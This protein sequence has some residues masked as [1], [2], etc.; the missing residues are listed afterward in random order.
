MDGYVILGHAPELYR[1]V[2]GAAVRVRAISFTGL[3]GIRGTFPASWGRLAQ[4]EELDLSGTGMGGEIP[5]EWNGM[6]SL[7]T[8]V[9]S[10]TKACSGLP[11]WKE[12]SMP[13]L[14]SVD[15]SNNGMRGPLSRNFGTFS[16]R[17]MTLDISGNSFCGCVPPTW[18]SSV[19]RDAAAAADPVLLQPNCGSINACNRKIYR[20]MYNDAA[21]LATGSPLLV[22]FITVAISFALVCA[23]AV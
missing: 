2:N 11:N 5:D 21:A 3:R 17:D 10:D 22:L 4:L 1:K 7:R 19:L 9:I 12:K 8:I 13:Q 23:S 16:G 6:S 15:F 18:A 20:C 14:V